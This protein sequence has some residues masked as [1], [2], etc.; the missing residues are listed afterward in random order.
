MMS[1]HLKVLLQL[2]LLSLWFGT[3]FA[4]EGK[5]PKVLKAAILTEQKRSKAG[6][7]SVTREKPKTKELKPLV[8]LGI[9]PAILNL[10]D[11][12]GSSSRSFHFLPF[13]YVIYRGDFLR[14]EGNRVR[15]LFVESKRFEL[16]I[17][18]NA[19]PPSRS[20]SDN[21]RVGMPDLDPTLEFG[22]S[23]IYKIANVKEELGEWSLLASL[24]VRGVI[25]TDLHEDFGLEG[26]IFHP[27]VNTSYQPRVGPFK[28]WSFGMVA[29]PLFATDDYHSYFY[30][31]EVRFATSSRTAFSTEG[32][33]SG[34]RLTWSLSKPFS[35]FWMGKFARLDLLQGAAFEDSPL[36]EEKHSFMA[37]MSVAWIFFRSEKKVEARP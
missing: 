13:P 37:G 22:P 29:G 4:A 23:I 9:G 2:M 25:A 3:P 7:Q 17:S 36:V 32:G 30:E 11:Y 26:F 12:R 20:D 27:S 19:S 18:L 6:N 21:A 5:L 1:L 15:G 28:G 24:A 33:Y 31:V 34:T 10:P 8:E 14:A 16:D 35:R